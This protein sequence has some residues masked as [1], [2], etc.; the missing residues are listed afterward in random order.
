M[1]KIHELLEDI[2]MDNENMEI[3]EVFMSKD[4]KYRILEAA[5]KKAGLKRRAIGRKYIFSFA[6]VM[7]LMLSFAAV[8]AQG[9]LSLIYHRI[10]GENIK[11]INN[12]ETTIGERFTATGT[13]YNM[14][15]KFGKEGTS[16]A[17]ITLNIVSMIGDENSFYIIAELIRENG[18]N[19]LDSDYISFDEL[20]LMLNSSGGYT[21]YQVEDDDAQD[22]KA[23]FIIA[24]NRRK[25]LVGKELSLYLKNLNEYSDR[26][27]VKAFDAYEFLSVNKSFINQPLEKNID[28][29]DEISIDTGMAEEELNKKKEEAVLMPKNV[30]P[31]KYSGIFVEEDFNDIYIE[32]IGFAENRLC[33]RF[34]YT[35]WEDNRLGQIYFVRKDNKEDVKHPLYTFNFTDKEGGAEFCYY[36]FDIKSMEELKD[37]ELKYT[38]IRKIRTTEGEWNVKFKANYKNTTETVYVNKK[39][40]IKGRE[41]TVRNL[42]ISPISINIEMLNNLTDYKDELRHSIS[43]D[44]SVI[45]KD[46]SVVEVNQRGSSSNKLTSGI[47]LMFER[48][49]DTSQ[50]EKIIVGSIEIHLND[51]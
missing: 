25:N 18:E 10:F 16:K 12:M 47:N 7:V 28:K 46:G 26:E 30:L 24:G 23:T 42:K 6:A 34:G 20:R 43:E 9:G 22:N 19:F 48:P 5:L 44:V 33:I 8:Y 13:V 32:N 15:N 27:P 49:V 4:E 40:V 1:K 17:E 37:Y 35:N 11:Y 21:W 3:N 50:I 29:P 38:L 51:R 36:T 39:T 41:Y 45:L 14:A 31:R 2:S